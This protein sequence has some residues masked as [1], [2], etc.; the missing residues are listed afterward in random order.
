[1][2]PSWR[3][4]AVWTTSSRTVRVTMPW[5]MLCCSSAVSTALY[6]PNQLLLER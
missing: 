1:M 6:V 5:S 2:P 3:A 4:M